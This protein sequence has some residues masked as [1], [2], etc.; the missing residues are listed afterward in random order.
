MLFFS[1]LLMPLTTP[2]TK[3]IFGHALREDSYVTAKLYFLYAI[4]IGTTR[5]YFLK[6]S[7]MIRPRPKSYRSDQSVKAIFCVI[8]RKNF[9]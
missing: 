3:T 2:L 7:D 6:N 1:V 8:S 5:I 4:D 9:S